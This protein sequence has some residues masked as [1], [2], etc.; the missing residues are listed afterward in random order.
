MSLRFLRRSPLFCAMV[1]LILGLGIGAGTL[2]FTAID[3]FVLRPLPV[4]RPERLARLGVEI[5]PVNVSFEQSGMYERVLAEQGRSFDAVFSFF[6]VDA[7]FVAGRHVE[8]V[9]C[10][11][12]SDNYFAALGLRPERGSFFG[13][14]SLPAVVSASL[15][16]RA[17]GGRDDAIGS[18]VR[19]RGAVFTVAGVIDFG[20]LDLERRADVWAPKSA[21]RAWSG[22]GDF[23]RAPAQIFVRLRDGVDRAQAEAEV[24]LLYPAMVEADLDGLKGITPGDVARRKA[25]RVV[26]EAAAR[27]VSAMRKQFSTAAA[28]LLGAVAALL[29]LM[30]ANVGGLMLARGE[31]RRHEIALRRSLGA[32]WWGVAGATLWESLVLAAAGALLGALIALWSGPLLLSFLPSRRPLNVNL[33]PDLRVLAF[34]VAVTG[35]VAVLASIAPAAS[36]LRTDLVQVLGKSG[37]R[38]TAPVLGRA[39]VAIQVALATVLVA[40]SLSLLRSLEALRHQDPGFA[41]GRLIVAEL[42]PGMAGV[43]RAGARALYEDVLRRARELPGAVNASLTGWPLMRGMGI[44]TTIGPVG[45]RL[46]PADRLN[47]SVNYASET[48]FANLGMKLLAGRNLLPADAAASPKP[49]VVT[50]SF[51]RQFFP[52]VDPLGREFGEAGPDEVAR[53]VYRVVGVVRDVKYRGMREMAPPTFFRA[54]GGAEEMGVTLHV[55][56][57]IGETEMIG[58]IRKMLAARGLSPV[59]IATMEQ[60]IETSMWQERMLAALSQVFAALAALVAGIGLFGLIA[61]TLARRTREVGI[62]VA[63]GATP[64]GIAALFA[65]YAAAAVAPG[66]LL[67]FAAFA[68]AR[69]PLEPLLFG[70]RAGAAMPLAVSALVL[71]LASVAAVGLPLLRATRIQP[72]AALREE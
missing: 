65:R 25:Q 71:V 52:D 60:E 43:R 1:V 6:A 30:A 39:M 26:L 37:A 10:E 2:I 17:L 38:V 64:T 36:A 59:N 8:T 18:T 61:F 7:A 68:L 47:V 34:A 20:G 9:T 50:E 62:R 29:L 46:T 27:G 53:G 49:V 28:V 3:A 58:Q 41:R 44:K 12:V 56:T 13:G 33:D 57:G 35:S 16:R 40:G 4:V 67:G 21:W 45:T 22:N 19:V 54:F 11:V 23:R 24:R 14:A 55:R 48:H 5:S 51:A 66:I 69:R 15:W 31:A 63:V 42:D 32:S 72:S 70:S